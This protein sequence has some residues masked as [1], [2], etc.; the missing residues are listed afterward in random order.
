MNTIKVV[1]VGNFGAGKTSLVTKAVY[2]DYNDKMTPTIGTSFCIKNLIYEGKKVQFQIWDTSGENMYYVYLPLYIRGSKYILFC[3]DKYDEIILN[4]YIDLAKNYPASTLILIR[5]KCDQIDVQFNNNVNNV[6][7]VDANVVDN[8]NANN[9]AV[10]ANVDADDDDRVYDEKLKRYCI[11][12]NIIYYETSSKTGLGIIELFF[13][14]A[15]DFLTNNNNN[16]NMIPMHDEFD[17]NSYES[18]KYDTI[19]LDNKN[20][21]ICCNL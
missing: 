13:F 11:Y 20:K 18:Y 5:T 3:I 21:Y 4:K 9:V 16:Y 7:V 12:N 17:S 8:N 2:N 14:L 1:M 10:D 19:S 15:K 6:D